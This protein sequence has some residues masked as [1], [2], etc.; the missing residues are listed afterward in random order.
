MSG[1]GRVG[2][3]GVCVGLL[4]LAVLASGCARKNRAVWRD[5]WEPLSAE[6]AMRT[7]V[8]TV[9]LQAGP[10]DVDAL[11]RAGGRLIGYHRTTKGYA[12]RA[13]STGGTHF[14][15]VEQTAS[16]TTATCHTSPRLGLTSCVASSHA[17]WTRIAVVRVEP[18]RWRELPPS[19]VPLEDQYSL[20]QPDAVVRTECK[21]H[22]GWGHTKCRNDWAVMPAWKA[23]T[24]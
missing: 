4:L 18:D 24:L 5:T 8:V 21:V 6:D 23:R 17:K 15:P 9:A 13:G 19:L 20:K 14:L 7:R 12:L 2:R 11:L 1:C 3:K 16:R 22:R 10:A